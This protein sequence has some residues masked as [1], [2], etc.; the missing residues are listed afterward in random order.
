MDNFSNRMGLTPMI[1][2]QKDSINEALVNGAWTIVYDFLRLDIE[3][4]HT[5]YDQ[6]QWRQKSA[7]LIRKT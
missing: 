7:N 3:Y 5:G 6:S 2:V 1:P 4:S